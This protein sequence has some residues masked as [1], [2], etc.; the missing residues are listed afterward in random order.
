MEIDKRN[1]VLSE[2]EVILESIKESLLVLEAGL[3][4]IDKNNTVLLKNNDTFLSIPDNIISLKSYLGM[5]IG[6]IN[7]FITVAYQRLY[8]LFMI[9]DFESKEELSKY[10]L[11]DVSV[12]LSDV[13]KSLSIIANT[14]GYNV[15]SED[16]DIPD[17]VN[18][19]YRE[20]YDHNKDIPN[21]YVER[22]GKEESTV[23]DKGYIARFK[24]LTQMLKKIEN[25]SKEDLKL[26]YQI[27]DEISKVNNNPLS[28]AKLQ[29]HFISLE[30][31]YNLNKSNRYKYLIEKEKKRNKM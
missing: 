11:K 4:M 22:T 26:Y 20:K 10:D 7:M 31:K 29:F 19:D 27:K 30:R 3:E 2:I 15:G 8:A 1:I 5:K 23:D 28:I 18:Y 6:K 16:L 13:I 24:V 14:P 25:I 21:E 17:F 9:N 12:C